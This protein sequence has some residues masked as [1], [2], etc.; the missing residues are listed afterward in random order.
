MPISLYFI[1]G[2]PTTAWLAKWCHAHTW[3][4]NWRSLGHQSRT[5]KLNCCA[6]RLAP[7]FGVFLMVNLKVLIVS[8]YRD[9]PIPMTTICRQETNNNQR[10]PGS[11]SYWHPLAFP[12]PFAV[13]GFLPHESYSW[14]SKKA[15]CT[16][17]VG[18]AFGLHKGKRPSE[19][20]VFLHS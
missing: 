14:R 15:T 7:T 3:D 11:W 2:M 19:R 18:K 9:L 4:P 12:S 10:L 1:Y 6:T 5:C 20:V 13:L 16:L 17:W 8:I